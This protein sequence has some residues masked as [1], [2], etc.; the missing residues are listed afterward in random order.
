MEPN[1]YAAP[2]GAQNPYAAPE[3]HVEDVSEASEIDLA[4]R[5]ARL[6][7]AII[8]G[9]AYMVPVFIALAAVPGLLDTTG[10]SGSEAAGVVAVF[11]VLWLVV[12]FAI[13]VVLLHKYGQTT[14]KKLMSIKIIQVD[15]SRARLGRTLGL[16]YIVN[17][18]PSAVPLIGNIYP[19]VDTLLIFRQDR[20][21]IHD[22]IAGTIVVN[23]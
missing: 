7:A 6:V 2:R 10:G 1:A 12:L 21:C 13:N 20:R 17:A 18:L 15:G 4:G 14:G 3:A 8:D 9:L 23:A 16:R 19:L 5:G 22:F 11:V